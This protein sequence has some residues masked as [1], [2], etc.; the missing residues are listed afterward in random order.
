ML[1]LTDSE[2]VYL[3]AQHVLLLPHAAM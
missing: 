3:S 1:E 2:N